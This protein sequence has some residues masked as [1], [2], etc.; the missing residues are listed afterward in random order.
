MQIKVT[1]KVKYL[2]L[3]SLISTLNLVL[4]QNCQQ[5]GADL[6]VPRLNPNSPSS[7]S[8]LSA[9]LGNSFNASASPLTNKGA[10]DQDLEMTSR[11]PL[12]EA[13]KRGSYYA[14]WPSSFIENHQLHTIYCSSVKPFSPGEGIESGLSEKTTFYGAD[15]LR[16]ENFDAKTL[17]SLGTWRQ[18]LAPTLEL[19]ATQKFE[20]MKAI[21]SPCATSTV[22]FKG[23]YY[24]FF[25]SFTEG[26]A[27]GQ[28]VSIHVARASKLGGPTEVL[29]T[30]GW[31]SAKAIK[32]PWKPVLQSLAIDGT[33]KF[34]ALVRDGLKMAKENW[35][36]ETMGNI[37]WG[38]GS[39]SA[40]VK[41]DKIYLSA[42]DNFASPENCKVEKSKEGQWVQTPGAR[43]GRAVF[44]TSQ[45]AMTF[46]RLQ[47]P[48]D[49]PA[50]ELKLVKEKNS[51]HDGKF[52]IF[53]REMGEDLKAK[54]IV[55]WSVL[56][57]SADLQ[58]WSNKYYLADFPARVEAKNY[59]NL[60]GATSFRV[61]GNEKGEISPFSEQTLLQV[62]LPRTKAYSNSALPTENTDIYAWSFR[63]HGL[64]E[65]ANP[66]VMTDPLQGED[67]LVVPNLLKYQLVDSG[68]AEKQGIHLCG[69]SFSRKTLA[70]LQWKD[71]GQD[72][73]YYSE[74][75]GAAQKATHYVSGDRDV[76][77]GSPLFCLQ[78]PL[79]QKEW[80][81]LRS[82]QSVKAWLYQP[83][84]TKSSSVLTV[85]GSATK[86]TYPLAAEPAEQEPTISWTAGDDVA[87]FIVDLSEDAQFAWMWS[88]SVIG[89]A[90]SLDYSKEGWEKT[91]TKK[92]APEK[93]SVDK[94]YY[95]RVRSFDSQWAPL[96]ESAPIT[97]TIQAPPEKLAFKVEITKPGNGAVGVKY[98]PKFGWKASGRI[99]GFIV[100]ISED[101]KFGWFWNRRLDSE[102]REL[103]FADGNWNPVNTENPAPEKLIG[104]KTYYIRVAALDAQGNLVK[105]SEPVKF[106]VK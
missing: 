64:K 83:L 16:Y 66:L 34:Q 78:V 51:S 91:N 71:A 7:P 94:T 100:D 76:T 37:F 61:A 59:W 60:V 5:S 20:T 106:K 79:L 54:N 98:L 19:K 28:L 38:V 87:H 58:K 22:L 104:R 50:G 57:G 101:S 69:T 21:Q 68:P 18:I 27:A 30:E 40:V 24:S 67:P 75:P 90:R 65:E 56:F 53:V 15:S 1:R 25:E 74:V 2:S 45:D 103:P 82:G 55:R 43:C 62:T 93:L 44:L 6:G 49:V 73:T 48:E 99:G 10:V 17:S 32:A 92:G 11:G 42:W 81:T 33:G 97:F 8:A 14:S 105:T 72:V 89:L 77:T 63:F 29:T 96:T 13:H 39:P 47:V 80:E 9:K 84:T 36:A 95:V 31:Q 35:G 86:V 26:D 12:I 102:A 41:G 46:T 70:K 23:T 85:S 4:F 3:I 52:A 88:Q